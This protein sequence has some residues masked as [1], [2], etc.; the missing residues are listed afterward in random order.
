MLLVTL[1]GA[2]ASQLY[3]SLGQCGLKVPPFQLV[4]LFLYF[5]QYLGKLS[6]TKKPHTKPPNTLSLFPKGQTKKKKLLKPSTSKT[7]V[8][9]HLIIFLTLTP[10]EIS[11]NTYEDRIFTVLQKP[12]RRQIWS[13]HLQGREKSE[14]PSQN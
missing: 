8:K 14:H 9:L 10:E 6:K 13:Q 7:A 5:F 2:D 12:S 1:Q 11:S 4:K 3:S